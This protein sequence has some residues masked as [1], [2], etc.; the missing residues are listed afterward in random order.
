MS[1]HI[2]RIVQACVSAN[3]I[4]DFPID[5]FCEEFQANA[6]TFWI[7]DEYNDNEMMLL[8][9]F[10]RPDLDSRSERLTFSLENSF[11]GQWKRQPSLNFIC[12]QRYEY[13][14]MIWDNIDLKNYTVDNFNSMLSICFRFEENIVGLAHLYYESEIPTIDDCD[15]AILSDLISRYIK[16][17]SDE[18]RSIMIERRKIG[19]EIAR[20]ISRAQGKVI[21][22]SERL[23]K[24]SNIRLQLSDLQKYL[25]AA[26]EAASNKTFIEGVYD[27]KTK[28]QNIQLRPEILTAFKS[29]VDSEQNIPII[30][31]GISNNIEIKFAR[32]DLGLLMS[33]I[34]TNAMKYTVPMGTIIVTFGFIENRSSLTV[35]NMSKRLSPSELER[36]WRFGVRGENA[37]EMAGEGIGLTIVS[38]ICSAYNIRARL[39][40]R[41]RDGST[42][43]DLTLTLP[44]R[45][46][47]SKRHPRGPK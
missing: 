38:D 39:S 12:S 6:G 24:S 2:L 37:R 18:I 19:H 9:S 43:T 26:H 36:I 15:M 45:M 13:K 46:C 4:N 32:D 40:Q 44:P 1:M 7:Q 42:W 8:R 33:N 10:N 21:T 35:S 28:S 34:A 22:I 27:R 17:F 25:S 47:R 30:I 14:N 3:P 11:S 29:H 5:V 41:K 16:T 31:E 23:T 20:M